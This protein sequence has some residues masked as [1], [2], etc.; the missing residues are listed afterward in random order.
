MDMKVKLILVLAL[1]WLG[2]I[3]MQRLFRKNP[4][5]QIRTVQAVM[6]SELALIILLYR[7]A[8]SGEL[9][10]RWVLPGMDLALSLH[11]D[12][13]AFLFL[14]LSGIV[15]WI[16]AWTSCTCLPGNESSL[17]YRS[18]LMG[19]LSAVTGVFLAGD[20]LTL[21][22]FYEFMTVL[23]YGLVVADGTAQAR[24]AG[25]TYLLYG[26]VSGLLLLS[27][28]LFMQHQSG[29]LTV[30][31]SQEPLSLLVT[32]LL[33]I[34]FGIK[35]GILPMHGWM[36]ETYSSAP[37]SGSAVLSG[38]LSKVGIYGILRVALSN[39]LPA[40]GTFLN[41]VGI[42]AMLW[43]G[44]AAVRHNKA[45]EILAYSSVSQIGFI[46]MGLGSGILIGGQSPY[47]FKELFSMR[48]TMGFL[49]LDYF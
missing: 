16:A 4:T 47:G 3:I 44:Y 33:L 20:Y 17:R 12:R 48:S 1:P 26:I 8:L 22:L 28:I 39:P 38:V 32:F 35:A 40:V 7:E 5:G 13:F 18:I 41:V 15:W 34:G 36:P 25:R 43:G 2:V 6:L 27:G 23:S 30:A 14:L 45:R 21:F 10:I 37:A 46:L 49:N 24:G 9:A 42:V 31:H 19:T 11:M 29:N